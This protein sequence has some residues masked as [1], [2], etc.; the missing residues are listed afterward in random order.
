MSPCV[1]LRR[2]ALD[3]RFAVLLLRSGYD[4]VDALDFIPMDNFQRIFWKLRQSEQEPYNFQYDPLKPR[5][6]D[7]TGEGRG[8]GE[9][10]GVIV[11]L[12]S[13]RP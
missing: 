13:M 7:L 2:R 11:H 6:G 1:T 12:Y 3:Q 5:V 10:A 9:F 4:A 8:D